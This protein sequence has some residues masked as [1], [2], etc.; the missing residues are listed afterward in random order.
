MKRLS[1]AVLAVPSVLFAGSVPAFAQVGPIEV[2]GETVNQLIVFGDDPCPASTGNEI[3][4]C[5]RKAESERYRIP[6]ALRQS[7]SP[8]NEAWANR[9][10]AYETVG[11]FGTMS[12]SP[13]GY[14]GWTGCTAQLIDA[15]YKEKHG[16]SDIRFSQLIEEERAKRLGT[17]DADA[18]AE[19]AR[20]EQ[21]EKEYEARLKA[22]RDAPLPGEEPAAATPQG[23]Q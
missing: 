13:S 4:V 19:Q 21:I 5:A 3:V 17:I 10:E 14:G 11:A 18:A 2:A 6:E 8:A 20:V 7:E 22:E 23:G 12:C 16:S 9:V 1:L 15:A